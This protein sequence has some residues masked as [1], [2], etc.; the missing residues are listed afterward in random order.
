[1]EVKPGPKGQ[2]ANLEIGVPGLKALAAGKRV[3]PALAARSNRTRSPR[4]DLRVGSGWF[5][6]YD[7]VPS[8]ENPTALSAMIDVRDLVKEFG[9]FCA[10]DHVSFSVDEGQIFGFLGPNGAG[11]TTTIKMLTTV[12]TPTSGA[13]R[14]NGHDPQR[15]Q[16]QV[17]RS[18]PHVQAGPITPLFV[19]IY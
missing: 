2:F 3:W 10:V 8:E 15:Q 17:R 13:I 5:R 18:G 1:M 7:V 19:V 4:D 11:K 14:V 6:L 9:K 12:L 16:N